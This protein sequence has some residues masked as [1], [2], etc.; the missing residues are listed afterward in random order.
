MGVLRSAGEM[1]RWVWGVGGVSFPMGTLWRACGSPCRQ[2]AVEMRTRLC[3]LGL[4]METARFRLWP[5]LSPAQVETREAI[6]YGSQ[7]CCLEKSPS[8]P[9][10]PQGCWA[11]HWHTEGRQAWGSFNQALS[12]S[13]RPCRTREE[14]VLWSG[15]PTYGSGCSALPP[16]VQL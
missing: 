16:A 2:A 6:C 13:C 7:G 4:G 5:V 8:C 15:D 12:G 14:T 9:Q 3:S 1:G 11:K 10:M